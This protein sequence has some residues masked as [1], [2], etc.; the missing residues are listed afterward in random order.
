LDER[1]CGASL[2]LPDAS[3]DHERTARGVWGGSGHVDFTLGRTSAKTGK[4]AGAASEGRDSRQRFFSLAGSRYYPPVSRHLGERG[5]RTKGSSFFK[6]ARKLAPQATGR[7]DPVAGR[8]FDAMLRLV[9]ETAG[10]RG[11]LYISR[12][13]APGRPRGGSCTWTISGVAATITI[14]RVKGSD[15]QQWDDLPH[16][17]V[18]TNVVKNSPLFPA[19]FVMVHGIILAKHATGSALRPR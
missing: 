12:R 3:K 9:T 11:N 15:R 18:F 6:F 10:L 2:G 4:A 13:S 1:P 8:D 19:Q 17:E 7:I 16:A 14:L 5:S